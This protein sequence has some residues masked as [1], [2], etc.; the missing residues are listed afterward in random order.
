MTD[1]QAIHKE[2]MGE[3]INRRKLGENKYHSETSLQNLE[4][5]EMENTADMTKDPGVLNLSVND[6]SNQD[7][8]LGRRRTMSQP[9]P[10]SGS[11]QTATAARA[12]RRR[13]PR[14]VM[15]ARELERN[16]SVTRTIKDD[17]TTFGTPV[18]D[19]NNLNPLFFNGNIRGYGDSKSLNNYR[20]YT[21]NDMRG[22]TTPRKRSVT[23]MDAQSLRS[24]ETQAP[25]PTSP[26]DNKRL[27]A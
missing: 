8:S 9:G 18:G 27:T 24:M 16:D 19:G 17:E 13:P 20:I 21:T 6:V 7:E 25:P 3:I 4:E 10:A 22:G 11:L 26:E 12:V 5:S 1:P 14:S 23:T 2:V 15:Y